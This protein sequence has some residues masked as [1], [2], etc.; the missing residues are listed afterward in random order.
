MSSKLGATDLAK[1]NTETSIDDSER[2]KLIA[3]LILDIISEEQEI[4]LGEQS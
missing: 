3:N 2:V 4:V 1:K